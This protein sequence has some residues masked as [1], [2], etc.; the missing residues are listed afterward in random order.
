MHLDGKLLAAA[1]R[2]AKIS[3][4]KILHYTVLYIANRSR[5]KS[6]MDGQASS[7]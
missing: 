3:P 1:D 2:S 7:N 5:S 6:F 4:F